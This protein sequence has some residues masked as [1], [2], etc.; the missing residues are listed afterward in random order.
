MKRVIV[1]YTGGKEPNPTYKNILDS[2]EAVLVEYDPKTISFG[3]LLRE[4]LTQH[5][6]YINSRKKQ[7][8][9]AIWV[10]NEKQ[11]KVSV[12]HVEKLKR[13]QHG[14]GKKNKPRKVFIDIED[15]GPFYRAE[16]YHQDYIGKHWGSLD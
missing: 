4:S 13:Q 10:Q 9:S 15:A 3:D 5:N 14:F 6:P 12:K 16:E 2:T 7:Y 11:R 1:G 8:R